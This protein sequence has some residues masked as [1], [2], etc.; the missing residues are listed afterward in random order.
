MIKI[1]PITISAGTFPKISPTTANVAPKESAPTSPKNIRDG[2]ILKYKNANIPP[3]QS[4]INVERTV[5]RIDADINQ[6]AKSDMV[7]TP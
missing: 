6:K 4:A 3:T 1:A 2:K 5:S 7:K